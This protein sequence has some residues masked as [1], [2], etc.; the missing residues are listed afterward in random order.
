[1]IAG[2]PTLRT[3]DM[4]AAVAPVIEAGCCRF[5]GC[6]KPTHDRKPYCLAHIG[7]M[8]YARKIR[9]ELELAEAEL[10]AATRPIQFDA[11]SLRRAV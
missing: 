11:S 10:E 3:L 1:M 5:R 8:A 9:A 2:Q 6:M 7:C 4:R